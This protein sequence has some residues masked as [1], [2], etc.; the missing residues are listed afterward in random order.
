LSYFAYGLRDGFPIAEGAAN[1]PF[2]SKYGKKE[3]YPREA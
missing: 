2:F 3:K 1:L